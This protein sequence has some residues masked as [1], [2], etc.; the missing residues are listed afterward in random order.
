MQDTTATNTDTDQD[1]K[2][3][4]LSGGYSINSSR[5]IAYSMDGKS[6]YYKTV[7]N[8]IIFGRLAP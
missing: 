2:L 8:E 3:I 7:W 5:V 1:Q 6:V 4:L